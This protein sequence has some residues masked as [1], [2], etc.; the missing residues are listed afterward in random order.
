MWDSKYF[1]RVKEYTFCHQMQVREIHKGSTT[2]RFVVANSHYRFSGKS[3][4]EQ[5]VHKTPQSVS[6]QNIKK[7]FNVVSIS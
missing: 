7:N 4:K 1:T 5:G 2:A 6:W 3:F